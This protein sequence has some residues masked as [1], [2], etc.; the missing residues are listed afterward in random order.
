[1]IFSTPAVTVIPLILHEG[2]LKAVLTRYTSPDDTQKLG[3]LRLEV[4]PSQDASLDFCARRALRET[5]AT[6]DGQLVECRL[7]TG[8]SIFSE[9]YEKMDGKSGPHAWGVHALYCALM[10]PDALEG[11]LE[12][13]VELFDLHSVYGISTFEEDPRCLM[14]GD[15]GV[16]SIVLIAL[17]IVDVH[18]R[19]R[20]QMSK[21]PAFL[22][23]REFSMSEL[24]G[25]Y[26]ATAGIT[27]NPAN[28]RRKVEALKMVMQVGERRE[29]SRRP[30]ALYMIQG[31][32]LDLDRNIFSGGTRAMLV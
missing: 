12:R 27:I 20:G 19:E 8:Q 25:A 32:S 17:K 13:D 24:H 6:E 2:R 29:T 1:M 23:A 30:T 31:I 3:L 21:L 26:E 18:M 11:I 5:F 16:D 4:D 28:F 9:A 15:R 14:I 7:C 22:V 10:H